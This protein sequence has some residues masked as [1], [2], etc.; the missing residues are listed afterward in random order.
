MIKSFY[1]DTFCTMCIGNKRL[2]ISRA[3]ARAP[4]G[5]DREYPAG[6]AI[7]IRFSQRFQA[8]GCFAVLRFAST[9]SIFGSPAIARL[10]ASFV[11]S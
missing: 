6:Q 11:A 10:I 1:R 4:A 7:Y 8:N 3:R 5:A 9:S 2:R